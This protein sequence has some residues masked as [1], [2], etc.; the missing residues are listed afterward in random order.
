MLQEDRIT[1][2]I[3]KIKEGLKDCAYIIDRFD[4]REA[5]QINPA[6]NRRQLADYVVTV[7]P[8]EAFQQEQYRSNV[9]RKNI[10]EHRLQSDGR[11]IIKPMR[12]QYPTSHDFKRYMADKQSYDEA[13][14]SRK[15]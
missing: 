6:T 14:A 10:Q 12:D 1:T 2:N 5:Y 13:Q 15:S 8:T 11:P 9:H 4:A 3:K 7:Y